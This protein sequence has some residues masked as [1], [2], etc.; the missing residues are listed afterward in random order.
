M[1]HSLFL[2][3]GI[4]MAFLNPIFNLFVFLVVISFFE[5]DIKFS[6]AIIIFMLLYICYFEY[7]FHKLEQEIKQSKERIEL[8]E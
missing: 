6:K 2:I 4:K 5:W 8:D 3:G 7:K 1:V